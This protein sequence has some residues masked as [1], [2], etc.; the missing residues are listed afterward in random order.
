MNLPKQIIKYRFVITILVVVLLSVS[1]SFCCNRRKWKMRETRFHKK[2]QDGQ[3]A[4]TIMRLLAPKE[5]VGKKLIR[6]GHDYDGGYVMVD[7]IE[8]CIAYSFGIA[9]D[10][11]WDLGMAYRG[12]DVYMYDHTIKKLPTQ[13][14]R[15]HF[16]KNGICGENDRGENLK[17]F[18]E[19]LSENGHIDNK[20]II[21]K[22]D[23]EGAEWNAFEEIS[24]E[25][26]RNFRQII[27]E[28]HGIDMSKNGRNFDKIVNV[29][30]KLNSTHQVVHLHAC[31]YGSYN[32]VGGV[33][34]VDVLEVTYLIKDGNS[35]EKS[36]KS[37]PVYGLDKPDCPERADYYLGFCG[38]LGE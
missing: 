24:S 22:I 34:M 2:S 14:E 30:N 38:L 33:P 12:V 9:D 10:V 32:I 6:I 28:F 7:D 20:N 8:N 26:L 16:F 17:T 21:L 29:L 31:N 35:F 11:S 23:V 19:I 37:Y 27:V 15:F 4:L 13:N 5:V 18:Q 1:I 3:K 25:L 36:M